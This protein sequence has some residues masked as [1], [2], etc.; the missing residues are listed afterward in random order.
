M[1]ACVRCVYNFPNAVCRSCY[2]FADKY[3]CILWFCLFFIYIYLAKSKTIRI[4]PIHRSFGN[5]WLVPE[6]MNECMCG[7]C[8]FRMVWEFEVEKESVVLSL[9][10]VLSMLWFCTLYCI[11]YCSTLILCVIYITG[12]RVYISKRIWYVRR[13]S[14]ISRANDVELNWLVYASSWVAIFTVT[15]QPIFKWRF[16]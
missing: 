6:N 9:C 14:I 12:I 16:R 13:F 15:P 7:G 2:E 5:C 10:R 3:A 11:L 1:C 4:F 8:V